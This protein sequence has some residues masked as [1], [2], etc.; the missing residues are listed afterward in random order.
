MASSARYDIVKLL[1]QKGAS[2][3]V[4]HDDKI[5]PLCLAHK[6]ER[7]GRGGHLSDLLLQNGARY[8]VEDMAD[9]CEWAVNGLFRIVCKAVLHGFFDSLPTS[10]AMNCGSEGW[11][12]TNIPNITINMSQITLNSYYFT[13]NL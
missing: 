1:R 13:L 3:D 6:K 9:F 10:T 12:Y 4:L 5:T 11:M 7:F 2:W 8:R